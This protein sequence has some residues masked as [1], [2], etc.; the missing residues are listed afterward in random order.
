MVEKLH[1]IGLLAFLQKNS[2][3]SEKP[4]SVRNTKISNAYPAW[5]VYNDHISPFPVRY[6]VIIFWMICKCLSVLKLLLIMELLFQLA[7]YTTQYELNDF[8]ELR[9]FVYCQ[10]FRCPKRQ[11][12]LW[13]NSSAIPCS[14]LVLTDTA[15][16]KLVISQVATSRHLKSSHPFGMSVMSTDKLSVE[17]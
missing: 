13:I 4:N 15:N 10:E 8:C 6:F 16:K 3:N 9:I 5:T 2:S 7:S 12:T 11:V 17:E 1:P 14:I